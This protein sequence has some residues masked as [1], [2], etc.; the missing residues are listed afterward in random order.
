MRTNDFLAVWRLDRLGRDPQ[1]LLGFLNALDAQ[2]IQFVSLTEQMDTTTPTGRLVF[3]IFGVLAEY[4]RDLIRE[5]ALAGSAAARARGR[6][7]GRPRVMTA[8]KLQMA[9]ALMQDPS[10][11]FIAHICQAVGVGSTTLYRYLTPE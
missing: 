4:E 7:G 11:L 5:R 8:D 2:G 9:Q 6:L 1:D 10:P 3:Q